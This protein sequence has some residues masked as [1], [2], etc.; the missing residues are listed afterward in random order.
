[1]NRSRRKPTSCSP[2]PGSSPSGSAHC[3]I[4]SFSSFLS[5]SSFSFFLIFLLFSSFLHFSFPLSFSFPPFPFSFFFSFPLAPRPH[6]PSTN[7]PFI[8]AC[9]CM[10]QAT[11]MACHVSPDTHCLEKREIPTILKFNEIHQGN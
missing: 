6:P 1:M 10:H 3:A 2:V 11:H 5:L 4:L 9:I 7:I 8:R